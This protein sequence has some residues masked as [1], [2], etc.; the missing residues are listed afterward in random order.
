VVSGKRHQIAA[1]FVARLVRVRRRAG[2]VATY[3]RDC[4]LEHELRSAGARRAGSSSRPACIS[5]S[6]NRT[7]LV[8]V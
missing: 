5:C 7:G 6:A 1:G 8:L 2:L 3:D 4:F